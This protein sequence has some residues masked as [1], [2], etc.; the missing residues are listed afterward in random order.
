MS[1]WKTITAHLVT[2][3][4]TL[5]LVLLLFG[6]QLGAQRQPGLSRPPRP[7]LTPQPAP[8]TAPGGGYELP[9]VA[10]PVIPPEILKAADAD[11]QINIRV[12]ASVNR[13]VVNITTAS[14]VGGFFGDET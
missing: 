13:S 7:G 14:E 12:Y 3:G 1:T 4:A 10:A 11:E 9:A 5:A 6:G 2:V 8:R